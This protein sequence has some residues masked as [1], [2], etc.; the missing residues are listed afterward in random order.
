[1]PATATATATATAPATAE[2]PAKWCEAWRCGD[3]LPSCVAAA[4]KGAQLPLTPT[5]LVVGALAH[6]V[7]A[8]FPSSA[9]AGDDAA[10]L[11]KKTHVAAVAPAPEPWAIARI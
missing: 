10:P 5:E 6:L 4:P 1:M 9:G 3:Y 7:S 2:Q 11:K 8:A